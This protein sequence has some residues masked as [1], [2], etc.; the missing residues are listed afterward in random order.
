MP[1]HQPGRY[2]EPMRAIGKKHDKG[3]GASLLP[4]QILSIRSPEIPRPCVHTDVQAIGKLHGT[5]KACHPHHS[6]PV[7]STT[8][9]GSVWFSLQHW[10][11]HLGPTTEP[12]SRGCP[13]IFFVCGLGVSC[14]CRFV[15]TEAF[16]V[17]HVG[18]T[19]AIFQ[20]S[21]AGVHHHA[22]PHRVPLN[23]QGYSPW[24]NQT[25]WV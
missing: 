19:V 3:H 25:S 21:I 4:V 6:L 14:L 7:T 1:D 18:L 9:R 15:E 22:W 23:A 17:A 5:E 2:S 8:P 24:D 20:L 10:A 13:P 16:A 11:L 12:Q